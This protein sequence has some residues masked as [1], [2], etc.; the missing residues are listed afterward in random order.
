MPADCR[1]RRSPPASWPASSASIRRSGRSSSC[2][3]SRMRVPSPSQRL[4]DEDVAQAD[5][6][7]AEHVAGPRDAAARPCRPR[8]GLPCRRSPSWRRSRPGSPSIRRSSA[9]SAGRPCSRSDQA[10]DAEV[11]VHERLAGDR[12][13]AQLARTARGRPRPAPCWTWRRRACRFAG[14]RAAM[15]N[16]MPAPPRIRAASGSTPSSAARAS[17]SPGPSGG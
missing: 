7:A 4:A 12:A 2:A 3:V 1:P 5:V 11:R 10:V 13:D 17:P 16:V 9:R 6:A 14:Q 15:E 8:R